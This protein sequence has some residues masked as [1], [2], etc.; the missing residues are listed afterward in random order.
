MKNFKPIEVDGY[1]FCHEQYFTA[2]IQGEEVS[3]RVSLNNDM[4]PILCQNKKSG[5]HKSDFGYKYGWS[6]IDGIAF[7]SVKDL[8]LYDTVEIPYDIY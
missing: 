1:I 6:V 7:N 4:A 2:I 3:G 5:G 8:V